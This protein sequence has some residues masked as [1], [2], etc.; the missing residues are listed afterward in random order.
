MVVLTASKWEQRSSIV[1]EAFGCGAGSADVLTFRRDAVPVE[2][3]AST[4]LLNVPDAFLKIL[5]RDLKLA[6][7]PK[8]DDRG[9]T[10]DVHALRHTFGTILSTAGIAPRIAQAAMRR[11]SIDLTMSVHADSRLLDVQGPIESLPG[12][13]VTSKPSAQRQRI[14][15]GAENF[16][17]PLV[18]P[19]SD[20]S[21]VSQSTAVTY[22]AF[23]VE[24]N[25]S[26]EM[27]KTPQKSTISR[28]FAEYARR[29]SNPQPSDPK[30]DAL[31]N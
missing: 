1:D 16:V 21:S 13:T 18:A 23:S 10:V 25:E 5:D 22:P 31:S 11:L 30:S 24:M 9:R 3:P 19:T 29:E 8:R 12:M 26:P 4:P 17:A 2:R 28:S 14:A 20:V 27:Q 6:G 15:A 7:I